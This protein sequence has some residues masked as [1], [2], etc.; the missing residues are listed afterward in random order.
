MLRHIVTA[1]Y[2]R[3]RRVLVLWIAALVA[4]VV[5]AGTAGGDNEVD[6]T[7]PG[8]DSAEAVDLLQ[9]RF[10]EF[11]G[12]TVDVVYTADGGVTDA[13]VTGRIDALATELA[14]VPNVVAAEPGLVSPDGSTGVLQVRFDLPGEQLPTTSVERVMD[15]AGEAEGDGLRVELGGYPIETVENSEAGSESVGLVAALVILLVAFG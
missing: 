1:S 4:A 10:P 14:D 5:L 11:A 6:F 12:G 9:E 3:R 13:D 8:S 15:L 7:V 2:D